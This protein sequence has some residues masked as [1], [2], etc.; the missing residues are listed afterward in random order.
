MSDENNLEIIKVD[1][2]SEEYNYVGK[3]ICEKCGQKGT[4]KT[5]LQSLVFFRGFPCD[6]LNCECMGCGAQKTFVFDVRKL[7]K[8]YSKVFR[9]KDI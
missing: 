3:Q 9:S 7:F 2:V 1:S 5:N 8:E 4:Y 6:E